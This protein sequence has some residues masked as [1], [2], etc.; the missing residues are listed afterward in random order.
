MANETNQLTVLKDANLLSRSR[1]KKTSSLLFKYI[2]WAKC[3]SNTNTPDG[4]Y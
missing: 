2:S 3:R 4:E 1:V